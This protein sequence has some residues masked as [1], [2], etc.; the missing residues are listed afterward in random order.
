M[1][2]KTWDGV[3]FPEEQAA[4]DDT[5]TPSR[6]KAITAVSAFIPATE[7]SVVLGSL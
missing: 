5:A 2:A 4:P 3:T 6:S 1:A 7:N